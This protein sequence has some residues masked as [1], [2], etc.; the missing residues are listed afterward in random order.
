MFVIQSKDNNIARYVWRCLPS[1]LALGLWTA[2][3]E[4]EARE[5]KQHQQQQF[6]HEDPSIQYLCRGPL[7]EYAA[8]QCKDDEGSVSCIN[9]QFND[10]R[11][12]MAVS[13]HYKSLTSVTFHGNNF[14]ELPSTPLFGD[15]SQSSLIT[16]NISANYIV[17]LNS[18]I[19]RGL[20]NLQRFDMSNNEIVL[21]ESD[22]N[23]FVHTPL[24]T[25][26]YL[27]HAFTSTINRTVQ[28]EIL[29]RM[30][31]KANL[32]HLQ[33][34][35]L[36]YN[37]LQSVPYTLP[38]PFPSLQLL[39]LRQNFLENL[40]VNG[41]CIRGI[42]TIN[43]SRNKFITIPPLFQKMAD[44]N[45]LPGVFLMRNAFH[46]DCNSENY[47]VWIRSTNVVS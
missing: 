18:N 23:F 19:L 21:K 42:R 43:L 25:E 36:S 29:M 37:Y 45:A 20:P 34:L 8:C 10:I 9:T 39:D 17:S 40:E 13:T 28:F 33:T 47:I 30:F 44:A 5:R 27:R 16:L 7:A 24:I 22:V 46:C 38:C 15:S 1:L 14:G 6:V 4:V 41:T 12:F 3:V 32:K 31:E 2:E 11:M 26:L 35:D